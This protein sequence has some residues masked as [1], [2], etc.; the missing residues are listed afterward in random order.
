[1]LVLVSYRYNRVY[2]ATDKPKAKNWGYSLLK[3][4]KPLKTIDKLFLSWTTV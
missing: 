2:S 4:L 1:V 3:L